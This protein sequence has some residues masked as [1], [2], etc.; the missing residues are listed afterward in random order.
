MI[1]RKIA[2]SDRNY[3][4]EVD[5]DLAKGEIYPEQGLQTM[6]KDNT[7]LNPDALLQLS[8]M[9]RADIISKS[10]NDT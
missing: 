8:R 6:L 7:P 10:R 5:K 1:K 4:R 2:D 9:L 3:H